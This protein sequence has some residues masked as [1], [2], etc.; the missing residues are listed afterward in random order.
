MTQESN[1][2]T[3]KVIVNEQVRPDYNKT[4]LST[5]DLVVGKAYDVIEVLEVGEYYKRYRIVDESGEDYLYPQ[6]LFIVEKD[7]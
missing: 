2:K 6:G 5:V 7:D 3:M 4:L 1:S